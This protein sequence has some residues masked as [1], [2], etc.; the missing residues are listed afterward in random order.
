MNFE[1]ILTNTDSL[2]AADAGI[3][4]AVS[5]VLGIVIALVYAHQNESSKNFVITL[6]LLPVLVQVVM[7]MV[8]GNL[9]T[10]VAVMGAFSLV[11]F[12]S[13]PGSSRE[14]L[15]IFFAMA[16][17]LATGEG[18]VT[19]AAVFTVL[20]CLMTVLLEKIGFGES[21]KQV[22][23]DLRVTIPESLN[24]SEVFVDIFNKYTDKCETTKVRTTNMGAM[25]EISYKVKLKDEA[26]EKEM[27]DT[28]RTRNG[29][30]PVICS[31]SEI[32][33]DEL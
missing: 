17:G 22:Y 5:I 23:K 15:F 4:A 18:Y 10:G 12:R 32:K 33:R 13:V 11:R 20:L 19:F 27:I 31:R 25:Y 2:T 14:I 26:A 1:S 24:Y 7:M 9:G 30:L 21:K 28:I 29:N 8:N 6:A 3:C 16:V